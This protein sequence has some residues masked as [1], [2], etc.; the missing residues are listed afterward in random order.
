[1]PVSR[2]FCRRDED[3]AAANDAASTA[4]ADDGRDDHDDAIGDPYRVT[5]KKTSHCQENDGRD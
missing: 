2:S 1:M 3:A 4:A 5:L